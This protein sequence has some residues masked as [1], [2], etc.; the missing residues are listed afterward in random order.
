MF[1]GR[2]KFL[3]QVQRKGDK[4][5]KRMMY[6]IKQQMHEKHLKVQSR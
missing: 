4:L 5:G 6:E 1:E 2:E 3:D